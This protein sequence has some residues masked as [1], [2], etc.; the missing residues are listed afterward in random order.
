MFT[1]LEQQLLNLATEIP[2]VGFAFV[3]SFIEEI[4]APIPSPVVMLV[5]GSLAQVQSFGV[6]EMVFLVLV[7]TCGKTLGAL[8]VY[9]IAAKGEDLVFRRASG[10]FGITHADVVRLGA[11]LSGTPKDYVLLTVLRALPIVPSVLVS[12]GGGFLK[13]PLRLFVVTTFLGTIVRDSL[14][15]YAG[16]VGTEMLAHIVH[17]SAKIEDYVLFGAALAIGVLLARYV[18]MKRRNATPGSGM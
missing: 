1:T 18:Y 8:L 3:A 9:G 13:L 7:A 16:Y 4:V 5:T 15:L 2:L 10:F 11:K 6:E 12:A 14:Y 17:T